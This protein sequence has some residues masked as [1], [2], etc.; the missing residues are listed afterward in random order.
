MVGEILN[1]D[2]LSLLKPMT[3]PVNLFEQHVMDL[4]T[5]ATSEAA[6][7]ALV[8]ASRWTERQI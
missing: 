4:C 2:D 8:S 1:L 7:M 5:P 3:P 6:Q